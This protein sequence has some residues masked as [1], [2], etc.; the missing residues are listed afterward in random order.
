MPLVVADRAE[1]LEGWFEVVSNLTDGSQVAASVTIVRRAPHG[2]D[3]LVGEMVFVALV[4]QL[5]CAGNQ[6]E[7]VDVAE[8]I[9]HSITKQPSCIK[10][11]VLT[12]RLSGRMGSHLHRED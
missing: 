5:V 1:Q 10:M 3:V 12:P 11:S 8:L 2:D 4:H 7:V 6:G 9:G